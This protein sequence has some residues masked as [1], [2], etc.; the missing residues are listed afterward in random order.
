[1]TVGEVARMAGITVRTLHHYDR[2]GLL[3]PGGRG[4]NGY[5][6]YERPDLERL[7]R[8]L[9]YRE[10]GLSLEAIGELLDEPGADPVAHLRRQERLLRDRLARLEDL[11]DAVHTSL[12]AHAMDIDLTPEERFELFGDFDPAEHEEEA[13]ERWGHTEA[14]RESRRRTA[15]YTKDDWRRMKEETA[16][17]EQGLAA[18]LRDGEPADGDRATALAEAHRMQI[19]HWFYDCPPGMHTGLADM[20]IADARFAKHYGDLEPGLARYVH[21]AIHANAARRAER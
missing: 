13:R 19:Q 1:M 17:V 9:S 8:I 2:I 11:L 6:R 20:Y 3:S 15:S 18:A 7:H 14:W 12:E 4:E 10:L 5:R 16:A 21:D